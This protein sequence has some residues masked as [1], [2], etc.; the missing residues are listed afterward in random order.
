MTFRQVELTSGEENLGE[1]NTRRAIF[2]GDA[3]SSLLFLVY[4][5]PLTHISRDA[6]LGYYFKSKGQKVIHL[7]FM[8]DGLKLYASNEKSLESLIHTLC[9]YVC[10]CLVMI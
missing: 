7:L 9:V 3:F 1:V 2:Q 4:L 5:L 6:A 10:V 8:D